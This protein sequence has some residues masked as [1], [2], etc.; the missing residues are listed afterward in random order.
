MINST[1]IGPLEGLKVLEIGDL[2]EVAGKILADA[3]AHVIRIE[4]LEGA[5]SRH[6]GPYV[7]DVFDVNHSLRFAASNTS[8]L[9]IT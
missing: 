7:D 6:Q 4:P 3:G 9:S 5:Q 1:I 8:K 2:A